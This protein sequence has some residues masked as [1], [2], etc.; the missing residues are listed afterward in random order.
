HG[1]D[2][3]GQISQQPR[4]LPHWVPNGFGACHYVSDA[5]SRHSFAAAVATIQ[6]PSS[7]RKSRQ[8][9][10]GAFGYWCAGG[11]EHHGQKGV[12]AIHSHKINN[13]LFAKLG[14]RPRVGWIADALIVV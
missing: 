7:V 9:S 10:S 6:R 12:V 4:H 8:G 1:A 5:S 3:S 14:E 11:V 2:A 13:A